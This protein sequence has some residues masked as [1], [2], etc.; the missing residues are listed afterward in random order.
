MMTISPS[1]A[2]AAPLVSPGLDVRFRPRLPVALAMLSGV[3]EALAFL[4][5]GNVFTAHVTG[6]LVIIAAILA[7]GEVPTS[8]QALALPAFAAFVAG[9]SA[10]VVRSRREG[11][12]LIRPLLGIQLVLLGAV[13]GLM[14]L[15]RGS[16]AQTPVSTIAALFAVGAIASQF[17]LLRTGL[18]GSPSTA[19]M[20][21]NLT[22]A[23]LAAAVRWLGETP[24]S[25]EEPDAELSV[26]ILL[27]FGAGC[28]LGAALFVVAGTWGWLAPV[29]I[30]GGVLLSAGREGPAKR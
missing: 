30:A 25:S 10:F 19:V 13:A 18:R 14:A 5:L 16:P 21:N 20:T 27:S 23:L 28:L 7:H 1:P 15:Q 24:R 26:R 11:A 4:G 8:A 2:P 22:A 6:N 17:V 3:I 12:S 9:I 29:A